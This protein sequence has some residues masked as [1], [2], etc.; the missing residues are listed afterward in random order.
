LSWVGR[1]LL[2][3]AG[4]VLLSVPQGTLL[5]SCALV[6]QAAGQ[7]LMLT[8]PLTKA[9]L[10]KLTGR[11]SI[12]KWRMQPVKGLPGAK[13]GVSRDSGK[14]KKKKGKI[15]GHSKP[16][17]YFLVKK[18]NCPIIKKCFTYQQWNRVVIDSKNIICF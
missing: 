5:G 4:S 2:L 3:L 15:G 16:K 1:D 12:T 10:L 17:Y 11:P 18:N 13:R 6:G 8:A 14:R 9:A 7:E